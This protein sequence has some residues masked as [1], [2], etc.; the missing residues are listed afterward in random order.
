MSKTESPARILIVEDELLVAKQI[1]NRLLEK[2]YHIAG[3]AARGEQAVQTALDTKPD[4]VL[5]DIMLNGAMD[6]IDAAPEKRLR[7]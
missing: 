7:F 1:E 6:G 4:L 3:K 2:G 5:M